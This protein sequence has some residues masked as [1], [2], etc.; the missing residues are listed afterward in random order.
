MLLTSRFPD[1]S[2]FTPE[3]AEIDTSLALIW[4]QGDPL[5]PQTDL[6]YQTDISAAGFQ[7]GKLLVPG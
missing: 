2:V 1:D 6:A 4:I 3:V 7:A 5:V